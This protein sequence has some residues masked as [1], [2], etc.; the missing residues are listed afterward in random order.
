[1]IPIDMFLSWCRWHDEVLCSGRRSRYT[2]HPVWA[3]LS[4][5]KAHTPLVLDLDAVLAL[6]VSMQRF[7]AIAGKSS[8]VNQASRTVQDLQASLCLCPHSLE[9]VDHG[10]LISAPCGPA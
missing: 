1:M 8:Q 10:P 9:R 3:I 5:H 6:P 2:L 7:Q 4:P